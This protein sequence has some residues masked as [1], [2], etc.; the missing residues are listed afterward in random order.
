VA[1]GSKE[2]TFER[3]TRIVCHF[4]LNRKPEHH[5]QNQLYVVADFMKYLKK[6]A[7]T[8]YSM[9]SLMDSVF[10]GFWR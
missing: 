10:T 1:A 7:L 9:S 3:R 6:S 2:P 5:N 4:P 8:G